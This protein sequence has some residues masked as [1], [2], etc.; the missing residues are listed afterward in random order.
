MTLNRQEEHGDNWGRGANHN[1][2]QVS[3]QSI[4]KPISISMLGQHILTK[5]CV[6]QSQ[7]SRMVGQDQGWCMGNL[8]QYWPC[9]KLA[10]RSCMDSFSP[11]P[12]Y[13]CWHL[14]NE[15]NHD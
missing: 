11:A 8:M 9:H 14:Q 6:N 10:E 13:Y 7:R 4:P 5:S 1:F 2:G 12:N 15:M 3:M